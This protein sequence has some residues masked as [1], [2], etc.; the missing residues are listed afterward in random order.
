M[1][2]YVGIDVSLEEVSLCVMDEAGEIV[3]E[4]KVVSDPDAIR[5][6]LSAHAPGALKI[7]IETGPTSTWL[8]HALKARDLPVICVDARHAKRVLSLQLNK[9]DRNDARGLARLMRSG[10]YKKVRVKGL[11]SHLIRAAL[12]SRALLVATRRD[13][14]NQI[15]G[16]LK[17]HGLVVGKA[18]GHVF[19]ARVRELLAGSPALL[20]AIEPLLDVRDEL[21]RHI[22]A[23]DRRTMAWARGDEACQRSMSVP[24]I[25]PITAL[26]FHTAIEDPGHFQRSRSVG[27]FFGLTPRRYQSGEIDR[28]GRIS[29]CGD[30]L[31]RTCLFEAAGVLLTRVHA[32]SSLKAWGVRLAKTIGF[33][34]AKIAVAR[35]LAIILHR[36]WRDGANFRPGKEQPVT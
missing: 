23:L 30:R 31:V 29:K 24:G 19:A 32:W 2:E 8:W 5:D 6:W 36:M 34:K 17:T 7:G 25:G 1:T 20:P 28:S 15:R 13:V 18:Y 11:D 22:D 21:G 14:Q 10:W 26:A 16:L 4:G 35:K 3:N 9:N 27:A 33:R 12:A